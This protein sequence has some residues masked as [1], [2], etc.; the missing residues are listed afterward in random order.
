MF[1]Y[2][3]AMS[4]GTWG[5]YFENNQ[6]GRGRIGNLLHV[7][8]QRKESFASRKIA[9]GWQSRLS[10]RRTISSTASP[11]ADVPISMSGFPS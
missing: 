2:L 11:R 10:W 9:P 4:G 6:S 5:T 7:P 8:L 3:A 1:G